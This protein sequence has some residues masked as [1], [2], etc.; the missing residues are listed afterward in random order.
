MSKI[1]EL[2]GPEKAAI[3][4]LSLGQDKAARALSC[5]A[6]DWPTCGIG[7]PARHC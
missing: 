7:I 2:T 6:P 1:H 4:L 5:I 3:L